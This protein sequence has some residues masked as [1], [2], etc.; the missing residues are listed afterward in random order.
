M[1]KLLTCRARTRTPHERRSRAQSQHTAPW[2]SLHENKPP[3]A[4]FCLS[5]DI[6]AD[7]VAPIDF[8][9]QPGPI[10]ADRHLTTGHARHVAPIPRNR[11]LVRQ[12]ER[13]VGGRGHGGKRLRRVGSIDP[14]H[15]PEALKD[16]GTFGGLEEPVKVPTSVWQCVAEQDGGAHAWRVRPFSSPQP[17][18]PDTIGT[19]GLA[20]GLYAL[21]EIDP[22]QTRFKPFQH[23]FTPARLAAAAILIGVTLA[24]GG[25]AQERP[26]TRVREVGDI[27]FGAGNYSGALTD[28]VEYERRKPDD[29]DVRL[30]LAETYLRSGDAKAAREQMHIVRDVKPAKEDSIEGLADALAAAGEQEEL[31][32]FLQKMT[33]ERG[34]VSDYM[35]L[36]T[37]AQQVG[38]VD[39]AQ[40]AYLQ[41]ARLDGGKSSRIQLALA[42]FY[43]SLGD[44]SN[45]LKRLRMAMYLDPKNEEIPA[46][47][48]ALGE[49]PGPSLAMPPEEMGR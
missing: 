22:M 49:I 46:R 3:L 16:L 4:R 39:E 42:D 24:L 36:G 23:S 28:Y 38:N 33:R 6:A 12:V 32:L 34:G 21:T 7:P 1:S 37:Y 14:D 17:E 35:R 43:E 10:G 9:G 13:S 41:A 19:D 8:N 29:V 26:L 44:K 2:P 18:S 20:A 47:V 25:C 11:P 30:R 31:M 48:R 40:E 15:N 45:A 27:K 5:P